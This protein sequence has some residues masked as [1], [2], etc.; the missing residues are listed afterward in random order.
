MHECAKHLALLLSMVFGQN[1]DSAKHDT[2]IPSERT[3]QEEQKGA[4]FSFP[5]RRYGRAKI[6]VK[7]LTIVYGFWPESE[8]FGFDKI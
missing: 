6:L 1:L 3:C 2:I 5:V 7:R 4:N 8:N